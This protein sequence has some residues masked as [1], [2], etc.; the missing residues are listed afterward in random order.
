MS[1]FDGDPVGDR[2]VFGEF[3][4]TSGSGESHI[5]D[6][7]PKEDSGTMESENWPYNQIEAT[8]SDVTEKQ[9][10]I[11]RTAATHK[12]HV[13]NLTSLGEY[14]DTCA[15]TYVPKVLKEYWPEAYEELRTAPGEQSSEE[16]TQ[17]EPKRSAS[18]GDGR[19]GDVEKYEPSRHTINA[20][21][22]DKIRLR[23]DRGE[24][25]KQIAS[26]YP[27]VRKTVGDWVRG[28]D[29]ESIEAATNVPPLESDGLPSWFTDEKTA[30]RTDNQTEI[31]NNQQSFTEKT[32]TQNSRGWGA[33]II[34]S[35]VAVIIWW[36]IRR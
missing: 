17:Y 25:V 3:D 14:L 11:I 24:N 2:T 27:A 16:K 21:E 7:T 29:T 26:D 34:T 1:D 36:V 18:D 22:L 6:A 13:D 33:A 32:G 20:E 9:E 28:V 15:G 19:W 5:T 31:N 4:A 30:E 35:L 10:E 12:H 8:P 23:R